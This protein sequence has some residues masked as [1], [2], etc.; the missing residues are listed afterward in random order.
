MENFIMKID[1]IS[2]KALS[3]LRL[4]KKSPT[5]MAY[6]EA[7]YEVAKRD[8]AGQIEDLNWNMPWL[9]KF[10]K[11]TQERLKVARNPNEF[12]DILSNILKEEAYSI[13]HTQQLKKLVRKLLATISDIFS[14]SA[15]NRL[16]FLFRSA[17]INKLDSTQKLVEF[18]EQFRESKKH[19]SVLK[20]ISG[21]ITHILRQSNGNEISRDALEISS[22]LMVHPETLIDLHVL[23]RIEYV[24]G[25]KDAKKQQCI[26]KSDD[27]SQYTCIAVFR[28]SNLHF[29]NKNED[30]DISQAQVKA[31]EILKKMCFGAIGDST[32]IGRHQ[33]GFAFLF[34]NIDKQTLLKQI[35]PIAI[36]LQKQKFSYQNV[37]FT[38]NFEF[39]VFSEEEFDSLHT[40]HQKISLWLNDTDNKNPA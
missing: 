13:E 11:Q 6:F 25:M 32:L 8:G 14:I 12:I 30:I 21:I 24:L 39:D 23:E 4:S 36:Q 40:L 16:H 33:N 29:L 2:R 28:I 9:N 35:K 1:D 3:K 22:I 38:F 17:G 20:R 37:L 27:L 18:W 31:I 15:K 26:A 7:F 19:I 5:P 34:A 10:D